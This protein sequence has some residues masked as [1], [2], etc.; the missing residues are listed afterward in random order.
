MINWSKVQKLV[1]QVIA[2]QSPTL[3][4][5]VDILKARG[6][7][8]SAYLAGAHFLK[9][10]AFGDTAQLCSIINAKSG[11][12]QENCSFCAQSAHHQSS[13]PVYP[14]KSKEEIIRGA[15]QAQAEGSHCYGIVTSGTKPEFGKEFDTVLSAIREIRERFDVEPSA[16]LGLLTEDL[17]LALTD[18]GCVTYHH[19]LE[20]ARSFFPQ[21][22]TTHDYEEDVNTVRLAKSAGMKVCCG[23]IFGLGESEEQRVELAETL[24]ELDVDS[25]PLNFLNPIEGTPLAQH[26]S[27]S[28]LECVRAITMFRY[29]LPTKPISVCGGRETNLRELQSWIFMAGASGTMVGNYLTTSGRDRAT[30]LQMFKDIEVKTHG[31]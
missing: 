1:D 3:D 9:E 18:A 4:Q 19:N 29:F 17:A 5:G 24:S 23:G 16:S 11:R 8:Y 25:V 13:P 26:S 31:C 10:Q 28:P 7:E 2:G 15:E 6:S 12:C 20:T 30:D 27:I 21:I 22:C 14:L